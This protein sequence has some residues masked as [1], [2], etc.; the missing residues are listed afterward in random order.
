MEEREGDLMQAA[1]PLLSPAK[2][3]GHPPASAGTPALPGLEF[4]LALLCLKSPLPGQACVCPGAHGICVLA[5]KRKA[6][7]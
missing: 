6:V 7:N 2:V 4:C 5:D 1:W 3:Q